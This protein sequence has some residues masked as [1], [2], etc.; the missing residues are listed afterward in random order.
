[1]YTNL[2]NLFGRRI[3]EL[4]KKVGLTQEELSCKVDVDSKSISRIE[5]GKFLPSLDL[6]YRLS[7]VFNVE[8]YEMLM[9]EHHK[10]TIDLRK[11]CF[12]LVNSLPDEKMQLGYKLLKVL[13][14]D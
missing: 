9:F 8:Y 13:A 5:T 3:R 12:E 7:K 2:K 10:D 6:L 14:E 1:M 11:E 4:R